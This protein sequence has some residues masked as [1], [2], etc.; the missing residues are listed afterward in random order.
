MP[1]PHY[2][3]AAALMRRGR[4][5][6]KQ[7]SLAAEFNGVAQTLQLTDVK[8][9]LPGRR[10]VALAEWQDRR[11]LAKVFL[12]P[13]A[14][15]DCA[16]ETNGHALLAGAG[17]ATA[18]LLAEGLVP[19]GGRIVLYDFLE[20]SRP[21]TLADVPAA[22]PLLA[23]LHHAGVV[24]GDLHPD[25]L[26]VVA[27]TVH[28]VDGGAVSARGS[29]M[30][31]EG[32][33]RDIARLLAQFGLRGVTVADAAIAAY[34]EAAP[35]FDTT[36]W[37]ARL[38]AAFD[39][40]LTERIRRYLEKTVRDCSE[41]RV[42]Q[43]WRRFVAGVRSRFDEFIDCRRDPDSLIA[44]GAPLKRG[45]SATVARCS[46]GGAPV[47]VKRYN[48]KSVLHRLRRSLRPSRAW[49]AWRNGH[50]LR[51]LGIAT[52]APLLLIEQRFGPLRG[53]A[54]LI[55]QSLSGPDLTQLDPLTQC[56]EIVALFQ[57]LARARLVHGDTKA[58]NFVLHNGALSLLDLDSMRHLPGSNFAR[59]HAADVE[60]FLDNWQA[61][62]DVRTKIAAVLAAAGL[63]ASV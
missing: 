29:P 31:A 58:T 11:A 5:L 40:A 54:Y 47:V 24:H 43:S 53:R 56:H 20:S 15:R 37:R 2:A 45:N 63:P 8:R 7:F 25:N 42:E 34:Q 10:V 19:A 59:A 30:A 23:R 17:V 18:A 28:I 44:S 32:R 38:D 14:E 33:L 51:M 12:G 4:A 57:G 36:D 27:G 3:S 61:H 49:H 62:P 39:T 52:A 46:I 16:R 26:L 9:V 13:Q 35:R 1:E 22:M 60:R 21:L 55:M 6:P 41:F 48:M 50:R